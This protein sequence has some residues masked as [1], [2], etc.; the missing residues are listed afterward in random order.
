MNTGQGDL[1]VTF[2]RGYRRQTALSDGGFEG[3]AACS[4]FC[5]TEAYASWIGTSPSGGF[6]DATI[7]HHS[8]YAHSGNSVGLLGSAN[9]HDNLSGTLTPNGH[10][11]TVAG[12]TYTITFFLA[13]D[14]SGS[15]LEDQ[16]F[17]EVR[18]NNVVV[19]TIR[20][21]FSPWT[22]YS[23]DVTAVGND[24]VAFRGGKAPAWTFIDDVF[25]FQ[26]NA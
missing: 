1:A 23:V 19:K 8:A 17:V 11:N 16:S 12:T 6:Q 4:D 26:T 9:G 5:F 2:S 14:F 22:Y 3:Y 18:W 24:Q 25:I 15:G 7:F 20:A 10:I 13:S 21:G